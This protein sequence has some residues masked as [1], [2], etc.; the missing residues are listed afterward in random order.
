MKRLTRT[1]LLK[2]IFLLGL[3]AALTGC[4][5]FPESE[6]PSRTPL[7]VEFTEWWGDYNL[8]I[9]QQKGFFQKHDVPVEL[10]YYPVYARALPD[11]AA[12]RIDG[13]L[14]SIGDAI[15]VSKYTDI[16]A[17]AVYDNGSYN[18][19]VSVP[20]IKR[21]RDLT[22][23]RIGVQIGSTY[24]LLISDMLASVG[25]SLSDVTLVNVVPEDVP[26]S[27]GQTI[28]AGF[29]Y[30]PYTSE[31]L[32]RG[33]NLLMRS[34]EF[35][36]LYPDVIVFNAAIVNERPQDI[37]AFLR[38]WFEAVEFRR[39]NPTEARQIIADYFQKPLAEIRPDDG[40]EIFGLED[41]YDLFSTQTA[42]KRSI[43]QTAQLNADFLVR[44][45]V[46]PTAP[47]LNILL[48]PEYLP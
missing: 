46:L 47:D 26:D 12:R 8:V 30:E 40:L 4:G 17:V 34:Q 20:E 27:L 48:T 45:G 3:A 35:V 29:V 38:A 36:G 11:L 37:R 19:I 23:K 16:K 41:N 1:S 2:W 18:T 14:F 33:N 7:R 44:I 39:Q 24:E 22:G 42:R 13:G 5:L 31:A 10:V 21:I 9:A 43:Y 32:S 28:D 6:T 25:M 15:S